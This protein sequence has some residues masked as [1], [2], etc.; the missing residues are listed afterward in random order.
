[1]T[2]GKGVDL[3]FD[4]AGIA[5]G[6]KDGMDA[7]KSR[8]TYLNVAGWEAPV[9]QPRGTQLLK[10]ETDVYLAV[11]QFVVPMEHFMMKELVLRVGMSY[12]EEDFREVV[13]EF[14]AG[15]YSTHF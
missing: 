9:S 15:E 3:V 4:C 10:R 12:T 8:G 11:P 14:V 2:G 5:P 6:L 13:E 1:L 7:L